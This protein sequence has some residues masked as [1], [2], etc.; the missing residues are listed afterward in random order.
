M[1]RSLRFTR[2]E[3]AT[4]D[5]YRP[6]TCGE[7]SPHT[8]RFPFVLNPLTRSLPAPGTIPPFLDSALTG[9]RV[10][11]RPGHRPFSRCVGVSRGAASLLEGL[12]QALARLVPDRAAHRDQRFGAR[13]VPPDQQGHRQPAAPAARRRGDARAGRRR[14][15]GAR[16]RTRQGPVHPGRGRGDSTR[17]RSRATT[18]SRSTSSCRTPGST[19]AISTRPTTSRRTMR[20]ARRPSR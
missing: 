17:S 3:P 1:V 8:T 4:H 16:L 18:R 15:Q 19:S 7:R 11:P 9:V 14:R 12:S 5:A 6:T 2:L 13:R 20:S 10:G